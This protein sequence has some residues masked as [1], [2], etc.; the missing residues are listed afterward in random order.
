M[1]PD[2]YYQNDLNKLFNLAAANADDEL[3]TE[4]KRAYNSL[5]AHIESQS[6]WRDT[7]LALSKIHGEAE[8]DANQLAYEYTA[9]LHEIGGVYWECPEERSPALIHHNGRNAK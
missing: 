2:Y 7:A 3:Y 8:A 4:C 9:T 6:S 5:A 1:P